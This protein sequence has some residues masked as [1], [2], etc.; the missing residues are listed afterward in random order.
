MS[1]IHNTTTAT[2]PH[3]ATPPLGKADVGVVHHGEATDDKEIV[4]SLAN[5]KTTGRT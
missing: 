5:L 4:Q 1:R 3:V 2:N